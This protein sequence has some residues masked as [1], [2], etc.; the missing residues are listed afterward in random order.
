MTETKYETEARMTAE[1]K[2]AREIA[3]VLVAAG[4]DVGERWVSAQRRKRNRAV[5]AVPVSAPVVAPA[6]VAA[7]VPPAE[8]TV[9][10]TVQA[11]RQAAELDML[12]RQNRQLQDAL[13]EAQDWTARMDVLKAAKL[14]PVDWVAK[15]PHV[16]KQNSLTPVLFTSDFQAGEV[17]RAD[18]MDG[19]NEFNSDIFV[20]R[21]QRMITKTIELAENNTGATDFP[22]CIY[23]RG[24]DAISG[25]IHDELAQTNDL[26]SIP[27]V[28]L[29]QRQERE[30]IRRLRDKF[31]RVRV[32]SVPGNHGRTTHKPHAKGY[33]ERSFESLLSWWLADAFESDPNVQF[34]Q[35]PSGDALF[36]VCGWNVLLSHGDR[37]G[38]KGGQGFVGPAATIARG[39][40]KLVQYHAASGSRVDVV[41]TGHLHTSLKLSTGYANG[42]LAGYNEY[43]RS[44]RA[45]PD[46]P[47]QWLLFMQKEHCVSHA[48]ELQLGKRPTR[49]A[50]DYQF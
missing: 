50:V 24:G 8:P 46:A 42:S 28:R 26:S 41:L 2:T 15:T 39:H 45:M 10:E 35:P 29:V 30:G 44:F 37:T 22:G 17:I 1:G 49:A 21:Y 27:A 31:G 33:A 3:A 34:W 19:L 7:P 20:E 14:E 11:R 18:E 32:I 13:I 23:L 9:A 4:H 12:R 5:K 16:R 36:D 40:Q 38:S 43:A 48:F 25:E 47:K 6:P